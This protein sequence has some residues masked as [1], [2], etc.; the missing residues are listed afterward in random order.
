MNVEIWAD[1]VCPWCG[2]GSHRFD[3]AVEQFAHGDE[4]EVVQRS[5]A[6]HPTRLPKAH[7]H[8]ET[9]H[10]TDAAQARD[11]SRGGRHAQHPG[12]SADHA[13]RVAG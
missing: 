4:V 7:D 10:P 9:Q 11:T 12:E 13:S 6:L 2:P 8:V 5:F 3:S 1:V